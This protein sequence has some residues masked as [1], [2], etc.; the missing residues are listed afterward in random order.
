MADEVAAQGE[1]FAPFLAAIADYKAVFG[2]GN[3][4][5]VSCYGPC[6]VLLTQR[7]SCLNYSGMLL[8]LLL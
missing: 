6:F 2:E 7:H 4:K 5:P 1:S 3:V 8:L